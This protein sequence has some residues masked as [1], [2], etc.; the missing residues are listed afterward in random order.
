MLAAIESYWAC[1]EPWCLAA[2]VE[3]KNVRL[4]EIKLG[5]DDHKYLAQLDW[6]RIQATTSILTRLERVS[7]LCPNVKIEP[8][9]AAWIRKI[10]LH[11]KAA[12]LVNQG[13]L[14]MNFPGALK[15][16]KLRSEQYQ[17]P[18]GDDDEAEIATS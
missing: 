11:E 8:S 1:D 10:S 3:L 13:K 17:A 4:V 12:R 15:G 6:Q 18:S 16:G 7:V 2:T 9:A 5:C 14:W